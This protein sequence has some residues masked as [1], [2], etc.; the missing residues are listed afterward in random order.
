MIKHEEDEADEDNFRKM[1]RP[2]SSLFFLQALVR[3]LI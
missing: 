2:I 3:N 1:A